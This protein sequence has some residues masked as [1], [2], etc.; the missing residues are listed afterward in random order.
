[1][2]G[3][4]SYPVKLA[5]NAAIAVGAGA[6]IYTDVVNL[7]G[8]DTFALSYKVACLPNTPNIKIEMEQGIEKPATPNIADDGYVVPETVSE[9]N[10]SLVD[11]LTHHQAI[12]PIAI[13]YL[14]LKITELTNTVTNS[15][16]TINLSVQNRF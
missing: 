12:F 13:K 4:N 10:A 3:P 15:V 16:L 11:E 7:S 9:I 1:M 6:T 14:R 8:V 5:G 2:N